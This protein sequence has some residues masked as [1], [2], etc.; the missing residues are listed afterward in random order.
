MRVCLLYDCLFPHTVGGAERWY[1]NLAERLA[2]DG[3][4]VT[5]LTLRQWDR[6]EPPR[7]GAGVRVI[8]VGPRMALYTD[9]G[10]RRIAPPL[11]FGAGVLWHLLRH[12]RRYDVVHTASFPYFS[13]LAAG[14]LRRLGGYRLVVDW[15][16]VW[17]R[18]YWRD[19][20]GAAGGAVGYG[21]QLL[22]A[23]LRQRAFCFSRLHAQRLRGEGL[24]GE[25]TVLE[26]EYAG[27]LDPPVARAAELEVVFAGRM[28][29][30]K[31][32]PLAVAAVAAA[33]AR[34]PGLRGT[35]YG[36]G[37]ERA[38]VLAAV[39]GHAALSAPGFVAAE[40]IDQA[41][42]SALCMLAP[43]SREGY[44]MVV[45]EAA[46]RGTP[47]VVVA[48]ADNA[49]VELIAEGVNGFVVASPDADAIAQAIVRVHEAGMAL[50]EST[51]RWFADNARRLSLEGS[52]QTVL[53]SYGRESVDR[54]SLGRGSSY[55]PRSR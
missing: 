20:L 4:E 11:V 6:G 49:A 30:E 38:A 15:H 44:G 18:E 34:I 50:R 55:R 47:S 31:R 41:L 48:G 19:Y 3:H 10:R 29:P 40:R 8:A 26:G 17:S 25:V 37:P 46:A 32:A 2:A 53:E 7:I 22:C 54:N 1:R 28:I 16:E 9:D 5:Y 51:A 24:R 45:V 43:S 42:R 23:R 21:V 39:A 36:D 52:L 35:F 14:A 33:A 13:L 12:G 27:S